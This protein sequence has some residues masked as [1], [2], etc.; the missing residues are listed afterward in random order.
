MPADNAHA[1]LPLGISVRVALLSLLT[2]CPKRQT[3]TNPDYDSV[4]QH[5][6][7]SHQQLDREK[8]PPGE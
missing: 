5:S 6:E 1:R 4:R 2:A 7:E 8:G 3:I